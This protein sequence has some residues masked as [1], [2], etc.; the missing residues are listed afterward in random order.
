MGCQVP[1]GHQ[2]P[3]LTLRDMFRL[4]GRHVSMGRQVP[5][6]HQG[7]SS[8]QVPSPTPRNT[9]RPDG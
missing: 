5:R 4:D 3:S 2:V 9:F 8:R 6:G 1:R 7:P